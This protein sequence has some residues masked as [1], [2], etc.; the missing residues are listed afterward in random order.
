MDGLNSQYTRIPEIKKK[1]SPIRIQKTKLSHSVKTPVEYV[2][3]LQRTIG[4][5]AVQ[6]LTRS[7]TLQ[8]KLSI[9]QP[10]DVYEQE[11]DRVADQVMRMPE[12]AV[13]YQAGPVEDEENAGWVAQGQTFGRGRAKCCVPNLHTAAHEAAH[14][15]QQRAGVQL[16]R[17]SGRSVI[18]TSRTPMRWP[19]RSFAAARPSISLTRT[20][21]RATKLRRPPHVAV[22]RRK[23]RGT[24]KAPAKRLVISVGEKHFKQRCLVLVSPKGITTTPDIFIHFHGHDADYGL[25][26]R[27][28][29]GSTK[30]GSD[31]VA[32]SMVSA[33]ANLIALLPQGNIGG[34]SQSGGRMK[35]L[36]RLG[37]PKFVAAVLA[38]VAKALNI[39]SLKPGKIGVSGHSAGGYEGVASTLRKA[40]ALKDNI[41]EVTLMDTAYTPSHFRLAEKWLYSGSPG[42]SLR[43]VGQRHQVKWPRRRKGRVDSHHPYFGHRNIIKRARYNRCVATNVKV[44]DPDRDHKSKVL[45]HTKITKNGKSHA[46]VLVL[47]TEVKK[48]T[49][50]TLRDQFIDDA[51]HGTGQGMA[52]TKYF[53]KGGRPKTGQ[54]TVP[55]TRSRGAV[56]S[57]KAPPVQQQATSST[58][59]YDASPFYMVMDKNA[60]LRTPPPRFGKTRK[61][62]PQFTRVE[63]IQV[64][65]KGKLPFVRV[66]QKVG[67]TTVTL[68]WTAKSN[69]SKYNT[70]MSYRKHDR[71]H[72]RYVDRVVRK[73]GVDPK[74]YFNDFR[75]ITFLGRPT[76]TPIYRLLAEHLK[77]A[78]ATLMAKHGRGLDPT[79]TG[80]KLGLSPTIESIKGARSTSSLKSMHLFGLA[81]DLDYTSNP[82]IGMSKS[83]KSATAVVIPP[84]SLLV[85]GK[86]MSLF[87]IG[88]KR[89]WW[90]ANLT[91]DKILRIDRILETYFSYLDKPAELA[92]ALRKAR[93]KPWRGMS[94]DRARRRIK[95]DHSKVSRAWGRK[96]SVIKSSGFTN[97]KEELIK[98]IG[99]YWGGTGFGDMM[100]FDMRKTPGLGKKIG[101]L[102]NTIAK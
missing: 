51:L 102:R 52:G 13:Q 70:Q 72:R 100:H 42:K 101:T 40:G 28:R 62:I 86:R 44:V 45:Q 15:I 31:V 91:I 99:L 16:K 50:G 82:H 11:A 59:R 12:L 61:K 96:R 95:G 66:T 35:A 37:F 20:R 67:T 41:T 30:S 25:N 71:K 46:D 92:E 39:A 26:K 60:L 21:A 3:F 76:R 89:T 23:K 84:A 47:R 18:A 1:N 77:K 34:K 83:L 90:R 10:G 69:L 2:L 17:V 4:N 93:R 33:R 32:K 80:T 36:N 24:G 9:G 73:A 55:S 58:K 64:K 29:K 63:I 54:T 27:R 88:R 98:G 14:V 38:K 65:K 49:H 68:G 74:T 79:A 78:E 22:Q 5:Q 6:E 85:T 56:Q 48:R 7:G 75:H 81:I 87:V 43:I 53:G 19:T 8:A 94:A 57:R 97:Y